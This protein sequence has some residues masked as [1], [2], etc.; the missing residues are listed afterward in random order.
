MRRVLYIIIGVALL[1][2]SCGQRYEAKQVVGRFIEQNAVNP[3][4][5]KSKSYLKFDSTKV[6][7]PAA[8]ALMR[9]QADADPLYKRGIHYE[10]EPTGAKLF[11]ISM[12][13]RYDTVSYRQTFYLDEQ[14]QHVVAFKNA[15]Q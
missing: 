13:Y 3:D 1:C 11:Y 10:A 9:R 7:G 15:Q 2:A 12:T 8:I 6:V 5:F 4:L 14:L